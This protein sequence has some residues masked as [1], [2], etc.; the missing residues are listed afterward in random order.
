M[1]AQANLLVNYFNRSLTLYFYYK[2]QKNDRYNPSFHSN[3]AEEEI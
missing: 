2:R 1:L 3:G